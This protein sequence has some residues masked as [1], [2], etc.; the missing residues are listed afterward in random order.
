[1]THEEILRE[2][3]SKYK[4]GMVV[5]TVFGSHDKYT[6]DGIPFMY[7][8]GDGQNRIAVK[9]L[10]KTDTKDGTFAIY[11][12][13]RWAN[14]IKVPTIREELLEEAK[15]RFPIGSRVESI[16]IGY[17]DTIKTY[18]WKE[19]TQIWFG[20]D[21]YNILV[22]EEGKWATRLDEITNIYEIY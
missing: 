18:G 8:E 17:V 19:T 16:V 3:I 12:N 7:G 13:G 2:A 11:G 22:W 6:I 14:I 20:G 1:M 4:P 21:E 15:R 9:A 10:E 5:D